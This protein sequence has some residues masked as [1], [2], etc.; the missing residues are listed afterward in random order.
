M[1]S[2]AIEHLECQVK[3]FEAQI[4]KKDR[5]IHQ[6]TL[7][8]LNMNREIYALE[9]NSPKHVEVKEVDISTHILYKKL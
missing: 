2:Q 4:T 5:E 8:I 3:S 7:Q 9:K 6:Q 1:Q